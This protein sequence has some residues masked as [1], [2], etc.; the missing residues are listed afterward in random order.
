MSKI[1]LALKIGYKVIVVFLIDMMRKAEL[2]ADKVMDVLEEEEQ[3][4]E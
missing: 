3:D 1:R 2:V 4:R